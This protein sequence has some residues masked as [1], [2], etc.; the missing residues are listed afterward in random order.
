[1]VAAARVK[2]AA[3]R[4][5]AVVVKAMAAVRAKAVVVKAVP[6]VAKGASKAAAAR[7]GYR[8]NQEFDQRRRSRHLPPLWGSTTLPPRPAIVDRRGPR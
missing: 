6:Q 3:V 5:K 7:G 2:V 8:S 4:D 1:M